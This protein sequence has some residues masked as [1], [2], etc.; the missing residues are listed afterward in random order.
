LNDLRSGDLASLVLRV[1]E[2]LA[3]CSKASLVAYISGNYTTVESPTGHIILHALLR[4]EALA[5]VRVAEHEIVITDSGKRFL[6]DLNICQSSLASPYTSITET[7][8]PRGVTRQLVRLAKICLERAEAWVVFVWAG[9]RRAA[10]QI[11]GL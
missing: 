3:P 2:K 4:L 8:S 10:R 1:L 6:D 9:Q 7:A 5:L 11:G